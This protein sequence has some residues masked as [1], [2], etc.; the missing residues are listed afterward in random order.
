MDKTIIITGAGS[1]IGRATANAFLSAGWQVGLIGRRQKT[2]EAT[3][4]G[5]DRALILQCDVGETAS[6]ESAFATARTQW[7]RLGALF[8]NAGIGSQ[9]EPLMRPMSRPGWMLCGSI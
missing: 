1:G 3:A 5:H 2:L 7:G 6:V 9:L 8:N 4:G